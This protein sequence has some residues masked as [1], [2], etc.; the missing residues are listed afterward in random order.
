MT[1]T[2]TTRTFTPRA[3][4]RA[5]G[6]S[7]C[8]IAHARDVTRAFVDGLDPPPA[9]ETAETLVL[10]VSELTT[11]AVRHGGGRYTLELT[12][13]ADALNAAVSDPDPTPPRERT[14]DLDGGTGGFGWP[15]VRRLTNR[16]TVTTDPGQ[17]KTIRAR[18]AREPRAGDS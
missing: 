10:V 11:N 4:V 5:E 8:G 2:D 16:I 3:P 1:D 6:D 18:L 17:G 7:P 12:A 15:M 14:P 13:T 9:A